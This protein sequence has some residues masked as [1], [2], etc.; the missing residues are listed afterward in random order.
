MPLEKLIENSSSYYFSN[1][2]NWFLDN[3]L[4]EHVCKEALSY[5]LVSFDVFDTAITRIVDSP[6]DVMAIVEASLVNIF[7]D[8]ARGFALAREN[9]ER[10]ARH[11]AANAGR[12]E[13]CFND[14]YNELKN[15]YSNDKFLEKAKHQEIQTE[16]SCCV[17]NFDI[18][19]LFD[20]LKEK[21]TVLFISDMYHSSETISRILQKCGY[22]NYE[23]ILV[24]SE[25]QHT[26][27]SGGLWSFVKNKFGPNIR[28]L[29]IGDDIN[30]DVNMPREHGLSSIYYGRTRSERRVGADLTPAIVPFSIL[31][32]S[33]HLSNVS[34][35]K[36]FHDQWWYSLG[37]SWGSL[38]VKSF[39]DWLS[40]KIQS[41]NIEHIYFCAR[42]GYLMQQAWNIIKKDIPNQITS[43][44]LHVSRRP[45]NLAMGYSTSTPYK[46]SHGLLDF[47]C[48]TYGNLTVND[49]LDRIT[50][51]EQQKNILKKNAQQYFPSMNSIFS[52][53]DKPKLAALLQQNASTIY[54]ALKENYDAVIGYLEQ[55]SLFSNRNSAIIDLGWAGTLQYSIN[56]ILHSCG[57]EN[58]VSGFY[59]GLSNPSLSNHYRAGRM[60]SAFGCGFSPFEHHVHLRNGVDILETLHSSRNG[61]VM[62]YIKT[63]EKWL[64]LCNE[65]LVEIKQYDLIVKPFQNGVLDAL[66][67][68]TQGQPVGPLPSEYV[69]IPTAIAAMEAVFCSP[70][71]EELKLLGNIVHCPTFEHNAYRPLIN[72]DIPADVE[73]IANRIRSAPWPIGTLKSWQNSHPEHKGVFQQLACALLPHLGE[74]RLRQ[75]S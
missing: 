40:E 2:K 28:L 4:I 38:I 59:Y 49:I 3:G 9:A 53:S 35:E 29:H 72:S 73:A 25:V 64:P 33:L 50:L 67:S 46:L 23:V 47:Y 14:I 8:K 5:D 42:D 65:N 51:P 36:R 63:D 17:P 7:G 34:Q 43:S 56:K 22:S 70:S 19:T 1:E 26:K 48:T 45:L 16:L 52:D 12:V 10:K 11:V 15:I 37:K 18:K 54:A 44:Y 66:T 57:S 13:I 68:W 61:S 30:G 24:S 41:E 69:S 20:R 21:T 39:I 60:L 55:E 58:K 75:F 71:D 32:R 62:S 6:V 27:G 31:H 74:R